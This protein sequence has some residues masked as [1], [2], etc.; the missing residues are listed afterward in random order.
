L[1]AKKNIIENVSINDFIILGEQFKNPKSNFNSRLNEVINLI[2]QENQWF[3]NDSVLNAIGAWANLLNKENLSNWVNNYMFNTPKSPLTVA[4]IMAGNI[5]LVGFHDFLCVLVSGNKALIKPS[6]DDRILLKLV[7]ETLIEINPELKD[8]IEIVEGAI[9]NIDAI[10]ATGSNNSARYFDYYF[11][12]YPNIIRKNRNSIAILSGKESERELNLLAKD[13]FNYYGL[14]CRNVSKVYVPLN[15]NFNQFFESIFE[16]GEVINH[17]KYG[18][19]YEYNRAV[20]LM[21]S[22]P[23]LDNNFLLLK[24][25]ES[26]SSPIGVLFYEYYSDINDVKNLIKNNADKIQCVVCDKNINFTNTVNFGESQ[27]PGLM[28]YADGVDVMDFLTK[29]N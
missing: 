1:E 4:I 9:K 17:N 15:Y 21:N 11:N 7:I 3:T 25:D 28:D 18:N 23:L 16:F 2:K 24:E 20:Y 8:R 5:P 10:I 29:L 19:N 14:G 22:V 13:I 26:L 12:K 27:Q 6:S